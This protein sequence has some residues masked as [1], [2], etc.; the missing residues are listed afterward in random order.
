DLFQPGP[1]VPSKFRPESH[2]DS[3]RQESE[4]VARTD[5]AI[6]FDVEDRLP[7]DLDAGEVPAMSSPRL[8]ELV[9]ECAQPD[10]PQAA[11]RRPRPRPATWGRD[12]RHQMRSRPTH[13]ALR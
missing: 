12:I 6:A 11:S 3:R 1:D 8:S 9:I 13:R 2:A 7:P 10:L 4:A 5:N